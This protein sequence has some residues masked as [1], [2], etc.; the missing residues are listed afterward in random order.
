YYI[1]DF[2]NDKFDDDDDINGDLPNDDI[3]DTPNKTT[4]VTNYI[5]RSKALQIAL[6]DMKLSQSDVYDIDVEFENK[7]THGNYVY[8]VSF[9]YKN[10]EYE[11]FIDAKT[12]KILSSFQSRD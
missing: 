2:E 5:S 10:N 6:K 9:D 7:T 8:E 1:D 12:G 3:N 11:Y 4:S